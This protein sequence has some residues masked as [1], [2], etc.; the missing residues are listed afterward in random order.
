MAREMLDIESRITEGIR[1]IEGGDITLTVKE[2][3]F[4]YL[5]NNDVLHDICFELSPGERLGIMD[6]T[7][8]GKTTLAKLLTAQCFNGGRSQG[9]RPGFLEW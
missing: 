2:L 8:C 9:L 4:G 5:D 7:G 3:S 1:E 6:E